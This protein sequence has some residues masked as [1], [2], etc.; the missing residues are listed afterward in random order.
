M[1]NPVY[2]AKVDLAEISAKLGH[3]RERFER[4]WGEFVEFRDLV[5]R[6]AA[7][8]GIPQPSPQFSAF[9]VAMLE[10]KMLGEFEA[11]ETFVPHGDA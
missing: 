7:A 11:L 3:P 8:L 10:A 2:L 9:G 1:T 5:Q 6:S 4:Q